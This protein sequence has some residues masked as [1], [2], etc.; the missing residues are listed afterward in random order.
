MTQK[1][2]KGIYFEDSYF[3]EDLEKSVFDDTILKEDKGIKPLSE[4]DQYQL[5]VQ[6]LEWLDFKQD[7]VTDIML[8]S[9]QWSIQK[10]IKSFGKEGKKSVLNEINNL[11]MKNNCFGEIK[12]ED[13]TQEMKDKALPILI[14][15][16]MKRNASL[17]RRGV[18]NVI[19]QRVY[20]DKS[21][22]SILLT[23]L[24]FFSRQNK[25]ENKCFF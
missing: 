24:D 9:K 1:L 6:A 15:M 25:R 21:N 2:S 13:L 19:I 12:Y 23:F 10:V 22:C 5:Y 14:F 17:K 8:Q 4:H 18:V 3:S 20:T 11:A 16:V 7:E